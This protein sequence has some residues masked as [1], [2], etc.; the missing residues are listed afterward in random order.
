MKKSYSYF[1]WMLVCCL[2]S[3]ITSAQTNVTITGNVRGTTS[4]EAVPAVSVLIKG[5][6]EGTYTDE[7][8]NFKITTAKR[9]PVTLVFSSIG[10][11]AQEV[12]VISAAQPVNV[13][14]VEVLGL[15][16]EVVVSAT[17]TPQRILES[18]VSI[19]RMSAANI[20]N[21][22]VPDYYEGLRNLKGVDLT[23]S[24]LTFKTVST[25]GFNGSGNLRF[26]QLIDGMD[27]QAPGLNFSVGSIV[28]P[29][30]L[31]I[32]NVELLPGASSALYGSGGM[33]G[34]MLISSKNPFKYQGLSVQV[35]QGVNHISD[36]LHSAAPY[37]DVAL[38]Y[39]K[40]ISD[41]FAFKISGQYIKAEDWH[42]NDTSNLLRTNVFSKV[43]PGTRQT[44]PN[45]DGINVF[46]DEASTSMN[47][48]A[49]AVRAQVTGI[50]GGPALTVLSGMIAAGLN[51]QQIAAAFAGNPA[52]APLAS[53][54]PFL[55]PTSPGASNP[56]ANIYGSQFVS[57]TGYN[58]SDLVDYSSYNLKLTGGLYYKIAG[59]V[60]AS[61]IGNWGTG[62][63]VYTGADRYSLKNLKMGQY[64][65][66]VKAANWF[67]RAYTTQENSG[68]S[69]TATTAAL[70]INRVWKK[71]QDWFAQYTGNYGGARLQGAPDAQAHV[72]ARTAADQGRLLPG[73]DAFK[74][75]FNNAINTSI[76]VGGAR[77]DD[78]TNLYHLEGQYNLSNYIKVVDVLVGAS[79][80]IYHLNS[81][82]TIF[83]D[84]TGPI[85]IH[86]AGAYVQL[87]KSLLDNVLTL[88]G[89]LR[90]D[91]HVN[92]KGRV[93]P[94]AT[95]LIKVAPNNNIRLSFQTAYRFPTAQDQYINLAAGG[96]TRLIGGLPQFNTYFG[97]NTNPSYTSES[98]VA[99]R[100]S[101]ATAP[102][103]GLL[104]KA[105]FET[106]KP[107]TMNSYEIGYRGLVTSK[108][109]IDVYG[110]YSQY[111]DFIGRVA[112]GRGTSG[113]PAKAPVDLASPFTTN[114]YSFV[115]NTSNNV[116]SIGWGASVQYE[117]GKGYMTNLNVSGDQLQNVPANYFTQFNTPKYRYNV[118]VS[119]NNVGRNIGFNI[120][121]RWQ[122]KVN[123]EG[124]FA[125]GEIPAFGTLDAQLGYKLPSIKTSI[126]VG[127]SNIL[128]KYYQSAFGNPRI[129]A[130]YYV[131]L[132]YNLF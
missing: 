83:V 119:N 74:T 54:L 45:Y 4:N 15:G 72:L 77:F 81:H 46:G 104:Q 30:E 118:G 64:K 100:N 26:N 89:S 61:L 48:I 69:Y 29:T 18:P 28:G 42:A 68:D 12:V 52:L 114:N 2:F 37:Y 132:G 76:N 22:A 57:R 79:Y 32:D 14:F 25:R 80:R 7:R 5:T 125:A 23:T 85:N 131:S 38:R 47:S 3:L 1:L 98:I 17:R 99:Y 75:A 71:D 87:Q 56:Y 59:N 20:A 66:E 105:Q 126:K 103:P 102:N 11:A 27:N 113:D 115:L 31:D 73:T 65:A 116:N 39:G 111:K 40:A 44:D 34:T 117:L 97:F 60:E 93:T 6:G 123:W 53:Y 107:E 88:T 120:M 90:Y 35:K 41:K 67:L 36:P 108:L 10:Y 128:N 78:R 43:K 33:N 112:V 82:G 124:T 110:Y 91:K 122:D 109:L 96:G 8:G 58:E 130:I 50:G 24:S 121:W 92:F 84:T 101:L 51:P 21:A 49:Q 106:V 70:F 94:R 127:G 86:E 13:A 63:T 16:Q 62:T 129:G 9:L 95:A 19:E 55:I